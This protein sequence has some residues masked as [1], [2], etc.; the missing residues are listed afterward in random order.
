MVPPAPPPVALGGAGAPFLMS[1]ASEA[2]AYADFDA[3]RLAAEFSAGRP[4][5]AVRTTGSSPLGGGMRDTGG[6]PPGGGSAFSISSGPFSSAG[7]PT[8]SGGTGRDPASPQGRT[9]L[10]P[11]TELPVGVGGNGGNGGR[12]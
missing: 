11:I 8:S 4:G 5:R 1:T 9:G 2:Q 6:S 7:S 3:S 12:V 10:D